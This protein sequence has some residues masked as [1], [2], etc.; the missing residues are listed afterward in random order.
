MVGKLSDVVT[1]VVTLLKKSI[2]DDG[3]IEPQVIDWVSLSRI[4][5]EQGV[6]SF[7]YDGARRLGISIPD[8]IGQQWKNHI[9]ASIFQNERLLCSQDVVIRSFERAYI[10]VAVLKG[11]SAARYYPQPELRALGDIDLLINQSDIPAAREMLLHEGYKEDNHEHDFHISFSKKGVT[12]ELHEQVTV[13]PDTPG[14]QA[15]QELAKG[16]LDRLD[17]GSMC[18]YDFPVLSRTDQAMSLLLHMVRHMFEGGIG[19]RQLCDWMVFVSTEGSHFADD[20]CPA[21]KQCGLLTF[22]EVSTKACEQFLGL[23]HACCY[24]CNSVDEHTCKLFMDSVFRGGNM[25]SANTDAMGSLFTDEKSMGDKNT[26]PIISFIRK[27]NRR[28]Y[29][30]FPFVER[31]KLLLPVFWVYLP[32]R[33][34]VRSVL[35]LR[36]KK[37]LRKVVGTAKKQRDLFEELHLFEI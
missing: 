13:F 18:G 34:F 22:A 16:F 9:T 36:P 26:S 30:S 14:G 28:I 10:N 19:L 3:I 8:E 4:A 11:S 31:F 21:L 35:G 7:V 25:G 29:I 1:Q 12:L 24:W 37:S 2:W 27:I 17:I 33:Y 20:V 5:K 6:A 32:I 15:A 23:D